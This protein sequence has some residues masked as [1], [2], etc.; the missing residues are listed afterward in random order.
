MFVWQQRVSFSSVIAH[1]VV[2]YFPHIL[3]EVYSSQSF[4]HV[5]FS[6]FSTLQRAVHLVFLVAS[7]V[8]C[9]YLHGLHIATAYC[10]HLSAVQFGGSMCHPNTEQ[11][12]LNLIGVTFI[13][14]FLT[15]LLW[16]RDG[17]HLSVDET[18]F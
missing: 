8:L 3:P 18:A 15:V 11:C 5:S 9:F 16:M 13:Q 14:V 10:S 7:C 17:F 4:P 6:L 12:F 2:L 1:G